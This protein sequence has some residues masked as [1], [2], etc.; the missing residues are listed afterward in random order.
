MA[1][2][3]KRRKREDRFAQLEDSLTTKI[4]K[5]VSTLTIRMNNQT[6]A[7]VTDVNQQM[8]KRFSDFSLEMDKKLD[9]KLAQLR[10]DINLD[11]NDGIMPLVYDHDERIDALEQASGIKQQN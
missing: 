6:N 8:D 1:K 4:S 5:A 2:T 9:T 11:T 7:I 3:N 10:E